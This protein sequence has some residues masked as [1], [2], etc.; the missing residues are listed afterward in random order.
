MLKKLSKFKQF[1]KKKAFISSFAVLSSASIASAAVSVDS[2]SGVMSGNLDM[3]PFFGA[4]AVVVTALA[5]IVAVRAG[6]R[7]LRSI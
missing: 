4:V 7:L 6:I 1:S 3:A 5:V 2:S